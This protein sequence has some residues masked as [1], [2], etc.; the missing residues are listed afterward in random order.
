M[1]M[2]AGQMATKMQKELKGAIADIL[3][4]ADDLAELANPVTDGQ[5]VTMDGPKYLAIRALCD[6]VKVRRR[7]CNDPALPEPEA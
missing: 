5:V 7:L 6:G 3:E 1:A 2:T 4:A